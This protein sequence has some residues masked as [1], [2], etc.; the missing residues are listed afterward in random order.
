MTY[1][2]PWS[3]TIGCMP[4]YLSYEPLIS[5]MPAKGTQRPPSACS[6]KRPC[7]TCPSASHRDDRVPV[8]DIG[9]CSRLV[10]QSGATERIRLS[11]RLTL[12]I[13]YQEKRREWLDTKGKRGPSKKKIDA[14]SEMRRF[15]SVVIEA[16]FQ[17][18][19]RVLGQLGEFAI[20]LFHNLKT[21]VHVGQK[22]LNGPCPDSQRSYFSGMSPKKS[23]THSDLK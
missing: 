8:A 3:L 18:F 4:K 11:D 17:A 16:F 15:T 10:F 13:L 2:S 20:V 6:R 9:P 21:F 19:H 12:H 22:V 23:R 14:S 5:H 7:Q 1:A